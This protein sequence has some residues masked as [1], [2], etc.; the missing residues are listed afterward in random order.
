MD[1]SIIKFNQASKP[2]LIQL[3]KCNKHKFKK[4]SL[5][6][7]FLRECKRR[8]LKPKFVHVRCS[9]KSTAATR[10][11][12][13]AEREWLSAEL[14]RFYRERDRTSEVI[15][16]LHLKLTNIL[17]ASEWESIYERINSAVYVVGCRL[18]LKLR[19]KLKILSDYVNATTHTP[20]QTMKHTIQFHNRTL[21]LTNA[22]FT[23]DEIN[24]LNKGFKFAPHMKTNTNHIKLLAART[25]SALHLLKKKNLSYDVSKILNAFNLTK[26]LTSR[27]SYTTNIKL[28]KEKISTHD[29]FLSKADKGDCLVVMHKTDYI[30]K[31]LESLHK[32]DVKQLNTNPLHSYFD[33][34]KKVIKTNKEVFRYF[35]ADYRQF[36]G[37]NP[38]VPTLYTLPKIHK[39]NRPHRPIV[40]FK[41]SPSYNL[42]KWLNTILKTHLSYRSKYSINNSL[43]L[44][45]KIKHMNLP[46]D[47]FIISFDIENLFPSVPVRECM[48]LVRQL[49]HLTS[50]PDEITQGIYNL[51]TETL[52]QN[53]FSFN[54]H[55]YQQNSG[56]AM[57]S[58]LSP[59]LAEI[60][61]KNLEENHISKHP[62]Y[63]KHVLSWHRFVDDILVFFSGTMRDSDDL[64]KYLNSI[65]SHITFTV[66]LESERS[67]PFLDLRIGRNELCNQ[68]NFEIY[69][70]PTT[71]GHLIPYDST[72]PFQH[73]I[74]AF[75]NLFHRAL[76]IPM[77]QDNFSK[78]CDVILHLA[79]ENGFPLKIINSTFFKVYN[80]FRLKSL[81]HLSP[82]KE[83]TPNYITIPYLPDISERLKNI[84]SKYNIKVAFTVKN[85][86]GSL[87]SV[88]DKNDGW[89][90]SGVYKLTSSC[91]KY[92]VGR[93]CRSM[94]VRTAEHIKH[95]NPKFLTD[96]QNLKA[97]S[98]FAHHSLTCPSCTDPM[99]F[100]KEILHTTDRYQ[101]GIH[102][103]NLEI[104]KAILYEPEL[105]INTNTDFP[106]IILD[107]IVDLYKDTKFKHPNNV[108]SFT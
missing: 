67:L 5:N 41:N 96:I 33:K 30:T 4:T 34:L 45:N 9:G 72:H 81:T 99:F 54:D 16:F 71:T 15:Y 36:I 83:T 87:L 75:H 32:A 19:N 12:I 51:L 38:T 61:L 49:L 100:K 27:S 40:N 108:I 102:L 55:L 25:E 101:D 91:G 80:K 98:S 103:E 17:H 56:L 31:S 48:D 14:R 7:W 64:L 11:R 10:A 95:L 77:S 97:K 66:E 6:I 69:R 24:I 50:L 39:V 82:E 46:P 37:R 3:Y 86:L 22:V 29:L 85:S 35:N 93:T 52:N 18:H 58:P 28:I 44:V 2:Q 92:Y 65:H 84:F 89:E 1:H 47:S 63:M 53:F 62:L 68:L 107:K 23:E 106:V 94:R 26:S 79:I 43:Q 20:V 13:V 105:I 60:F 42:S 59:I 70:K 90:R 78:E 73:K 74:A 88:P 21:N 76:H 8:G 104:T 57:G